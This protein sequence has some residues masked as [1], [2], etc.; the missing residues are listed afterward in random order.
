MVEVFIKQRRPSD[1]IVAMMKN[2]VGVFWSNGSVDD[3]QWRI[4]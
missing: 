3:R 2:W 4:D 1:V